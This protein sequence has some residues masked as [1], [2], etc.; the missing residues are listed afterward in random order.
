MLVLEGRC[1]HC[2]E[3][4]GF[5]IFSVSEYISQKRAGQIK[6]SQIN[7]PTF[8]HP[9]NI[10]WASFFAAGWC[11]FCGRPILAELDID[12]D[13]L[14]ALR[15][16]IVHQDKRYEGP[17]PTTKGMWPEPV[18]PYSHPS[19]PGK[20]NKIFVDLQEMLKQGLS[21][22]MVIGGCRAVM[23]IALK[24]LGGVGK[25]MKARIGD[26]KNKAIVNG[27][28]ADWATHVRLEGNEAL[29]E[30]EGTAEE[31]GELV[32]FT[33]LFLQ[34]AF[35]FPARVREARHSSTG[36]LREKVHANRP[37]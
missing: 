20:V 27:V 8:A 26:L 35:E 5:N 10:T 31:A 25:D 9:D 32:E 14:T 1:P 13:Y 30:L 21:P 22:A 33:K 28:L 11:I 12:S 16:H 19:L 29:H 17:K 23:E 6:K 36:I 37:S 24:E 7:V 34:Y 15:E 2:G 18:P 4:S 3:R